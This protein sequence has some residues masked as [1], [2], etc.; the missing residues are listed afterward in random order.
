MLKYIIGGTFFSNEL[1]WLVRVFDKSTPILD[2]CD[3]TL[4]LLP[5]EQMVY[6]TTDAFEHA[7][8]LGRGDVYFFDDLAQKDLHVLDLVLRH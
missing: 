4:Q 2:K 6:E 8:D 3:H 5:L 1:C 7:V